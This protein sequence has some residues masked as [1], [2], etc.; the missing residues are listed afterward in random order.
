V[1]SMMSG[2]ARAAV[3]RDHHFDRPALL[4]GSLAPPVKRQPDRHGGQRLADAARRVGDDL[5]SKEGT[6]VLK[7]VPIPEHR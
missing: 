5:R 4:A 2:D 6:R 3:P 7:P 1:I